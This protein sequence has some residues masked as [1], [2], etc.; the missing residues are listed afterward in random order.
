MGSL[1]TLERE[2]KE[3][4]LKLFLWESIEILDN[5]NPGMAFAIAETKEQAIY[6]VLLDYTGGDE[7]APDLRK[8]L[9]S[10]KPKVIEGEYGYV[11]L[12]CK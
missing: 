3:K 4:K 9:K 12:S 5:D 11:A 2:S 6:L 7:D 1:R 8:I 10:I